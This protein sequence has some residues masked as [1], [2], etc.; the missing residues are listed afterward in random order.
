MVNILDIIPDWENVLKEALGTEKGSLFDNIEVK[1]IYL[2]MKDFIP[3][4]TEQKIRLD[5][6]SSPAYTELLTQTNR[7][8]LETIEMNKKKSGFTVNEAGEV[9]NKELFPSIISKYRGH[10]LMVDFWATWCGPCLRAHKILTPMK[11][12]LKN[13][14]IIY[15]YITGE[16][17]PKETWDKMIPDI[18]GEHFRIKDNQWDYL[19]ENLNIKG[20]PTYFIIDREGNI[21]YR[22]TGLS[23]VEVIKEQLMKALEK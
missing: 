8:L 21:S 10:V 18:H 12:E 6:L 20:V 1:K 11:E 9:I 16:T 13:K 7:K 17:S 23:K 3:L 14:D 19:I 4:T 2:S 15:L 5:K 22:E